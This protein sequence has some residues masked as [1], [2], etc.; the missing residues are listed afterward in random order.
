MSQKSTDPT[1]HIDY[2][3]KDCQDL[4]RTLGRS[5]LLNKAS[6][7]TSSPVFDSKKYNYEFPCK[8]KYLPCKNDEL[9][10]ADL[11]LLR[12]SKSPETGSVLGSE[13]LKPVSA[14]EDRQPKQL[15][16]FTYQAPQPK[17]PENATSNPSEKNLLKEYYKESIWKKYEQ[18]DPD[19]SDKA[20]K[21]WKNNIKETNE[22]STSS[23][24]VTND[25]KTG[26]EELLIQHMKRYGYPADYA[27]DITAQ[28]QTPQPSARKSLGGRRNV[29]S[30]FVLP[31]L[32]PPDQQK[33][34]YK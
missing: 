26:R 21:L 9:T 8:G 12:S 22:P 11:Y 33:Q 4:L 14:L 31:V 7:F 34:Q 15:L 16:K 29:Q 18:S 17:Q 3:K 32:T 28:A 25:F 13:P 6:E 24:K 1:E 30:K 27:A 5:D 2:Y 20:N 10:D 23:T 19:Q